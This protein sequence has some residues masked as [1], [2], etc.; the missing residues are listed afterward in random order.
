MPRKT[1]RSGAA[2]SLLKDDMMLM[3]ISAA[4]EQ[5]YAALYDELR[6]RLVSTIISWDLTQAE[7]AKRLLVS[8]E[9][10]NRIINLTG[11]RSSLD[12]L[13][14]LLVRSGHEVTISIR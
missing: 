14:I 9:F 7:A 5:G 1:A 4:D 2:V 12:T 6:Q 8:R 11:Q 13:I 10:L 3:Q